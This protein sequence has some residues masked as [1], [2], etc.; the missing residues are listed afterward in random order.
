MADYDYNTRRKITELRDRKLD[1]RTGKL[2]GDE[3]KLAEEIKSL[4]RGYRNGD[5]PMIDRA[6][7]GYY[8]DDDKKPGQWFEKNGA[9]T[10]KKGPWRDSGRVC[11]KGVPGFLSLHY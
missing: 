1:A 4:G 8:A 2:K 7:N 5:I 9:D 6:V 11:T 3:K 10:A